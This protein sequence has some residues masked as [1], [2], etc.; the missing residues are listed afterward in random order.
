MSAHR[1]AAVLLFA[2]GAASLSEAAALHG[3]A[4]LGQLLIADSWRRMQSGGEVAKPWPWADTWPVARLQV[5]DAGVDV[6]VLAG[7]T[8]RTLAWGPGHLAG[9]AR[10]GGPGNAVVA[11]HRDTH[12]AFLRDLEIGTLI[13]TEDVDGRVQRYRVAGSYIT[14]D[15]D[16]SVLADTGE[17]LLTLVTCWP[18]EAPLPG[19]NQRYVVVATSEPEAST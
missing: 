17:R 19:G 13:L 14:Y 1:A 16:P 12:F 15:R 3:K 5:P 7:G 18:F 10:V 9:T 6:F 4:A 2:L 8:G 11:G